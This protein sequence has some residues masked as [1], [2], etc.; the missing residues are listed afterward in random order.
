[1]YSI[2]SSVSSR[3]IW[4]VFTWLFVA[5]HIFRCV[6]CSTFSCWA[7]ALVFGHSLAPW[8][9]AAVAWWPGHHHGQPCYSARWTSRP[10]CCSWRVWPLRHRLS[11]PPARDGTA[12]TTC[13]CERLPFRQSVPMSPAPAV[14]PN[15]NGTIAC[16]GA[17]STDPAATAPLGAGEP[18][19]GVVHAAVP[20]LHP[21]VLGSS[22]QLAACL[23]CGAA[24]CWSRTPAGSHRWLGCP[25]GPP[26]ACS[27]AAAHA[28][29][30]ILEP[31]FRS[32]DSV[33]NGGSAVC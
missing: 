6:T 33:E 5:R 26:S 2:T 19:R 29:L 7:A 11:A 21:A 17:A 32:A 20:P 16:W 15:S 8:G 25:R 14:F 30:C 23:H 28:E 1:M 3:P 12:N 24:P 10:D 9:Q 27:W 13:C 31:H 4:C 22:V 18:A